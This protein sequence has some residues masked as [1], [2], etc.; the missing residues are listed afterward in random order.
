[1]RKLFVNLQVGLLFV[2]GLCSQAS[3]AED[4]Y[5]ELNAAYGS[6]PL[7]QSRTGDWHGLVGAAVIRLQQPMADTRSFVLPLVAVSYR[8]TFYWHF[9]ETGVFVLNS[10]DGRA[11]LAIALKARRGYNPAD[12]PNLTGMDERYTSVEGGLHGIWLS[13]ASLISYGVFSDISGRSHGGS[14]QLSLAHPLHLAPRWQLVPSIGAEWLSDKVVDYYYGVKPSEA[15]STRPVY[16]GT[17]S[18]N[19]RLGLMLNYRLSR[20]WTLFGG[21]GYTR[22]GTGIS[23]SPIVTRDGVGAVHIGGGWHF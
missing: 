13:H 1:M 18:T 17:A 6:T 9:G 20:D 16:I 5:T 10:D 19:L 3:L 8:Q 14:A 7:N 15:T 22:L 11:R 4:V 12:Y 21:V 23:D 2:L